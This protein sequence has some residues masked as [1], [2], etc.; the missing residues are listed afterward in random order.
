MNLNLNL[1]HS[2]YLIDFSSS[3]QKKREKK[4]R[5]DDTN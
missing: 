1:S 4:K 3:F 2:D 5:Y